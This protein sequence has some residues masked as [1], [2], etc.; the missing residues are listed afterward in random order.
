[1]IEQST[2]DKIFA[3]ANIVEVIGDF[4]TL[5]RNGVNYKACC[6]FHDEKTPSFVVSPAKGFYKCF[7]CGKGGNVVSFVMDYENI[8]Y[9]D[10][11]I[12]L[13][14][15]YHIEVEQKE[16]T[17][18]DIARNNARESMMLINS[19]ANDFFQ[20]E[21]KSDE[22]RTIGLSY[23]RERGFTDS[24]IE[25]FNL[26]YC[27]SSGDTF[28][29]KALRAGYKEEYLVGTGL[30]IAKEQG[31]YY[32]R[33]CG[34][35]M[36]PIHSISGRV[37]AFGGRTLRTDKKVAKYLNS[38]ES[39]VYHK[40]NTLYGVFQAKKAIVEKNFCILVEGY[41]DVIS[42]HQ[43]GIENV[44]A[45][46][47]TSLT[48]EQIRL[49]S[50]FTQNVTVLYDGDSAGIKASM[51]GIDMILAEGLN[52]RVV[53][54]DEGEDPDSFAR[55]HS[56]EEL[57][58]YIYK[59][60]V[61]FLTFKTQLLLNDV[62]D[63]PIGR[64]SVVTEIINSI[65]VIPDEIVRYQFI[66]ECSSLLNV[67][68]ELISREV[69]KRV[70]TALHGKFGQEM[71]RNQQQKERIEAKKT[72]TVSIVEVNALQDLEKELLQYLLK[73]GNKDFYLP[74]RDA[75]GKPLEPLEFNVAEMIIDELAVDEIEFTNIS[76]KK[77]YNAYIKELERVKEDNGDNVV[78]I[79]SFMNIIDSNA[80]SF[81]VDLMIWDELYRLSKIWSKF[82][83]FIEEFD[84]NISIAV[85]KA[86]AY[87]KLQIINSVIA[88]E[89][90]RMKTV[91]EEE[92]L[93][94]LR[95]IN[96]YNELKKVVCSKYDR[97]I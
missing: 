39:E 74:Q 63:D 79:N 13:A 76:Y 32:D 83:A 47:G 93:N 28:S 42:L 26:G 64:A 24:T 48:I 80:I 10:A 97:V 66:G 30:T 33:F 69:A 96:Q 56:A 35:V 62:K 6:P 27:P 4:V 92:S 29:I 95:L 18:E 20:A 71:Y 21:L 9:V 52:V 45:S 78:D 25:K 1:M 91:D 87:Y 5:K 84:G 73:Y 82:D 58:E 89:M 16:Q 23:F 72:E 11:L 67:D 94:I 88:S 38:P 44:V 70:M 53:M 57:S 12:Y 17:P 2:I 68:K 14:K 77:L 31:G 54:L 86:I 43:S 41:T 37:I 34:R 7:G 36:F 50:R 8:G 90:E 85:P 75:D 19:Y 61:D 59:N 15:K 51:R 46:S 55:N 3:T 81:V 40:S 22:G 49:I 65:S 60:E